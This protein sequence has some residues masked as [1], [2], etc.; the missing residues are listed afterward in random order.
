METGKKGVSDDGTGKEGTY[1]YKQSTLFDT[2]IL[3]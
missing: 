1:W 3:E 2:E